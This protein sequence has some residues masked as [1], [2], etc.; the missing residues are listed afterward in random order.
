MRA[1]IQRVSQAQVTVD[2]AVV[3]SIGAGLLVL[4]GVSHDDGD[5]DASYLA[6]K[7]AG[8]RIF[9]DDAGKMN[10]SVVDISGEVLVVSQFTLFGDCRGGRRPS[11]GDAAPPAIA[12][13]LYQQYVGY[14]RQLG[15]HVE[16]GRFRAMMTVELVNEGPVTILLDSKKLF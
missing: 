13:E 16:T 9:E 11:F 15:L 6:T 14:L 10:R 2:G 5:A 8:L 1:V 7:T 4:L 3:G 12:D